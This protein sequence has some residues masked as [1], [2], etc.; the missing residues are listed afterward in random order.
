[1]S[2]PRKNQVVPTGTSLRLIGNPACSK[3]RFAAAWGNER[4]LWRRGNFSQTCYLG[5]GV[6]VYCIQNIVNAHVA[7]PSP[8]PLWGRS[9]GG[10]YPPAR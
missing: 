1:M 3:S 4:S 7:D 6:N 8:E 9:I 2:R 10:Q 5:T